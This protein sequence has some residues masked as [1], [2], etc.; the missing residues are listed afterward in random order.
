MNIHQEIKQRR[1]LFECSKC[2]IKGMIVGH[3]LK[4]FICELCG[5]DKMHPNIAIPKICNEC[6]KENKVCC[7]CGKE[8]D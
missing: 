2:Y 7:R 4:M 3:A 5:T 8:L 1:D 6:C